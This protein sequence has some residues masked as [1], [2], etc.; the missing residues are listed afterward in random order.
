MLMETLISVTHV[1]AIVI[2]PE[3]VNMHQR[4]STMLATPMAMKP[5]TSQESTLLKMTQL[6][7][8]EKVETKKLNLFTSTKSSSLMCSGPN[9]Q[10]RLITLRLLTTR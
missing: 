2:S 3:T 7:L 8:M 10:W 5:M 9:L 4:S 6:L 1:E